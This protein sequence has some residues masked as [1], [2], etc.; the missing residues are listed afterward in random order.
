MPH[1]WWMFS[2]LTLSGPSV[3]ASARSIFFLVSSSW[4]VKFRFSSSSVCSSFL[5]WL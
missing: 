4:W 2:A 5:Q 1:L 3:S